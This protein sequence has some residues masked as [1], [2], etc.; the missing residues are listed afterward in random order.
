[1]KNNVKVPF[2]SNIQKNLFL[3]K[4]FVG[5]LKFN[6]PLVN[7]WIRGYGSGST[8]T[9][10]CHVSATLVIQFDE[11]RRLSVQELVSYLFRVTFQ[12]LSLSPLTSV[13]LPERESVSYLVR[14]TFQRLS[15]SL[16]TSVRLSERETVS[17]LVRVTFQRLSLSLLTSVDCLS[18]CLSVSYH[19]RVTFLRSSIS[20]L[21]SVRLSE[22]ETVSYLVRVTFQRLPVS[23]LTS[24]DCLS[25][26][27]SLTLSGSP[28]RDR[29]YLY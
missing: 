13:R 17:Y 14:V 8:S 5:V 23:L 27:L 21:T 18:G 16:L 28:F 7:A 3:N 2:K 22:R 29:L 26:R 1:L 12:R 25:G 20:L 10:K 19:V 24:V 6:D 9:P 11:G 4:F 15:L